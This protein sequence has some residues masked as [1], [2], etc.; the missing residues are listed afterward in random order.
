MSVS[1]AAL[2]PSAT[3]VAA[4]ASAV[5][6]RPLGALRL[7]LALLVVCQH[8]LHLLPPSWRGLFYD[9]EMGV[10][11]VA[12]FF[13]ISGF[14]VAEALTTFYAGRP[15]AFLGNRALRLLPCY[16]AS[17]ALAAIVQGMLYRAGRLV[18]LN[19]SLLLP[20]LHPAVLASG[21]LEILPGLQPRYMI[22]YDFSLVPF[23]WTLR[24]ESAFYLAAFLAVLAAARWRAAIAVAITMG[25]AG[26]ALFLLRGHGPQLLLFIPFFL[27]GTAIFAWRRRGGGAAG[28]LACCALLCLAVAFPLW[29]QRGHPVLARQLALLGAL[30]AMFLGLVAQPG[31][32]AAYRRWDRRA[33][34]LSYPLYVGHGAV[35]IA[36]ADAALPKGPA[37]YAAGLALSLALAWALHL[38]VEVPMR[39]RRNRLRGAVL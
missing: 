39:N 3:R 30:L 19:G 35:L 14:I 6:Y 26:F 2:A 16:L 17:L 4:P 28:A 38:A 7:G 8:Q 11:A 37:L 36:L 31:T 22:G 13:V 12:V 24:V 10:V 18:P 5:H 9:T 21:V 32:S 15:W 23:A 25:Y 20:P 27:A 33:G 29:I 34:D 1:L